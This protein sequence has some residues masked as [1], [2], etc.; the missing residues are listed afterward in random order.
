MGSGGHRSFR[1][2]GCAILLA[3]CVWDQVQ[4]QKAVMEV[5]VFDEPVAR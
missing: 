1:E 2:R 5:D 4:V 3:G